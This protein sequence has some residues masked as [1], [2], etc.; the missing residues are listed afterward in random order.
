[1]KKIYLA[2]TMLM[3]AATALYAQDDSMRKLR[4]ETAKKIKKRRERHHRAIL[5]KRRRLRPDV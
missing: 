1:M 3:F 5:E 2:V 4:D